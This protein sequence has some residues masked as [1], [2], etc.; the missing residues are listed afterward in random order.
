LEE[1]LEFLGIPHFL[2][3]ERKFLDFLFLRKSHLRHHVT[4]L[5]VVHGTKEQR[6]QSALFEIVLDRAFSE[7]LTVRALKD[8]NV[9]VLVAGWKFQELV[10]SESIGEAVLSWKSIEFLGFRNGNV[11]EQQSRDVSIR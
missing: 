8:L 5:L 6:V 9:L 4:T 3:E 2:E 10:G 11:L 7:G 1:L